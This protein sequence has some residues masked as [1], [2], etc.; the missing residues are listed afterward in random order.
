MKKQFKTKGVEV[1]VVEL[2]NQLI[3]A[4]ADYDNLRKRTDLEKEIWI[5]FASE[6]ILVS[7]LPVLDSL[8]EALKHLQDQGLAM[9]VGEFKK[10]F[11]EEGLEEVQPKAGEEFNHEI[12]EVIEVEDGGQKDTIA[13][14]T[15]NGWKFKEGKVIR[16]A[17]VKVFTGKKLTDK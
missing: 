4:L 10:I 12:H 8:E 11:N 7:L 5:K 17:K 14:V 2:K 3:R 9:A 13:E 16:F 15:L 6:R 1:E